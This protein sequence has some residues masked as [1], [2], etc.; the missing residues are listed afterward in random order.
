MPAPELLG[1]GG[2]GEPRDVNWTVVRQRLERLQISSFH[3]QR[4][5]TG[6]RFSCA[7]PGRG[8]IQQVSA[9]GANEADA[10]DSALAQAEAVR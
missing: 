9:E 2:K 5:S 3:L 10:I 4:I 1:L 8:P 7:V 6:F